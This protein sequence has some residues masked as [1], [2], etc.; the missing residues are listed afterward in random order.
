MDS[1]IEIENYLYY[2]DLSNDFVANDEKTPTYT[3]FLGT[4]IYISEIFYFSF[5]T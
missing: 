2:A 1:K 3:T 5:K 4:T